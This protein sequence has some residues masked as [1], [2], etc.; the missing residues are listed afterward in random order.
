MINPATDTTLQLAKATQVPAT[1]C[2]VKRSG[3]NNC[4]LI[5]DKPAFADATVQTYRKSKYSASDRK[6][7]ADRS[8][9]ARPVV[10]NPLK[11]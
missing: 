2:W 6:V 5:L 9:A 1:P 11:A 3:E 4:F 8:L 10:I 7:I